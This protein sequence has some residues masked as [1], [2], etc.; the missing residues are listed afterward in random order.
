MNKPKLL[1]ISLIRLTTDTKCCSLQ[2]H[3][4]P[5]L[6]CSLTLILFRDK[7]ILKECAQYKYWHDSN[8]HKTLQRG[9]Q[10]RLAHCIWK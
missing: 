2:M 10:T 3:F 9:L 4:P 8:L 1:D 5:N 7:K 6:T